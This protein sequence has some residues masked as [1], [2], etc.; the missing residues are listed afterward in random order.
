MTT[1]NETSVD[2]NAAAKQDQVKRDHDALE[3]SA[4]RVESSVPSQVRD[5]PVQPMSATDTGD[6]AEEAHENANA[7]RES[8]RRVQNSAPDLDTDP[9]K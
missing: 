1:R 7:A 2:P 3:A 9:R 5:T 6:G 4:R 8:A